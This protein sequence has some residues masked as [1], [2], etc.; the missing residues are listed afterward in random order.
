[1]RPLPVRHPWGRTPSRA[2]VAAWAFLGALALACVATAQ[3]ARLPAPGRVLYAQYE[4]G[5]RRSHFYVQRPGYDSPQR[6]HRQPGLTFRAKWSPDGSMIA[7]DSRGLYVMDA[8]GSHVEHVVK[9]DGFDDPPFT[10]GPGDRQLTY[11]KAKAADAGDLWVVDLD[12][13][14]ADYVVTRGQ[15]VYSHAAWSPDRTRLAYTVANGAGM[16]YVMDENGR[17]IIPIRGAAVSADPAWSPDG[18]RIAFTNYEGMQ[19]NIY[20]ADLGGGGFARPVTDG[21]YWKETPAWVGGGEWIAYA[22]SG[23]VHVVSAEGGQSRALGVQHG[24]LLINYFDWFDPSLAVPDAAT[25]PSVWGPL[26]IRSPR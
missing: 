1:M 3:A 24:E 7:F 18:T 16:L 26:K 19:S 23:D 21:P 11:Y 12:K 17:N 25:L 15:S 6:V 14:G 10:W 20:V 13:P 9:V 8:D 2:A 5:V 22:F 4:S